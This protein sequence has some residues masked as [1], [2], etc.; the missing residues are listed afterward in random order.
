VERA[1]AG[2]ILAHLGD[3]RPGV[4]VDA[5]TGVPDI[6]WCEVPAGPFLM[7][8]REEDIPALVEKLGGD[9]DEW[10]EW[11]KEETPQHRLTLPA[12]YISRYPITNAQFAA[13]VEAGGYQE[14]R[15]WTEAEAA[16]VWQNSRVNAWLDDEPRDRLLDFG[17]PFNLANHPAVGITWYEAVAFCRWLTEHLRENGKIAPDQEIMLPTEAQWEKASRG[18]DG[19]IYPWG[20]E[21]DPDRAN[22]RDTGIGTTSA[23][24]CFPAGAS[25]YDVLDMSGNIW[26]WCQTKW[27]G[28]YEEPADE[29]FDGTGSRVLRGG[30]WY[31]DQL[32]AR[33]ASRFRDAPAARNGSAGFRVVVS[34]GSP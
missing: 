7:G 12:F 8:T 14:P 4:G 19:R 23:V 24:G 25:P 28:S 27:R 9:A 1:E 17:E 34:P 20:A 18:T 6:V 15:Y 5:G 22:Y 30:L 29:S 13:F 31:L 3:P 21:P 32:F 10:Y 26:E 16:D 2:N 33:C 11:C